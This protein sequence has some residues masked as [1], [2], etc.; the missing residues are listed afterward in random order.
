MAAKTSFVSFRIIVIR[1]LPLQKK[2]I[3]FIHFYESK[4]KTK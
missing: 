1:A 2:T 4:K 3:K